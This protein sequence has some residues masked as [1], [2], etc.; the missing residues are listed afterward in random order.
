M[1]KFLMFL[2]LLACSS[3]F[4]TDAFSLEVEV[5]KESDRVIETLGWLKPGNIPFQEQIQLI[6]DQVK[7][8]NRISITLASTDKEDI[9][10]PSELESKIL[11]PKILSIIFT[12]QFNCAQGTA[13]YACII[14]G[15]ENE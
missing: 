8:K 1:L 5:L 9:R 15:V 4:V 10:L 13:E 3:F 12:N 14:V 6:I 11:D 7:S 2:T